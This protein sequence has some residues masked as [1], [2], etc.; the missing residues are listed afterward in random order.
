[1]EQ[2]EWHE[3]SLA[4]IETNQRTFRAVSAIVL[5]TPFTPIKNY[6]LDTSCLDPSVFLNWSENTHE[7]AHDKAVVFRSLVATVKSQPALDASLETKAVKFL[8]SVITHDRLSVDAFLG[9]FASFCDNS[10]TDFTQSVGVLISS[11]SQVITTATVKML[12]NLVVSCSTEV[13]LALVKADL[14]PRIINTLNPYSISFER[15]DIFHHHLMNII[16][17]SLWLASPVALTYLEIEDHDEQQAVHE[18]VLKQVLAPSEK[19]I[20]HLCENRYSIVDGRHTDFLGSG[21]TSFF[22]ETIEIISRPSPS[23]APHSPS[24]LSHCSQIE[25][26]HRRHSSLRRTQTPNLLSTVDDAILRDGNLETA[27]ILQ[28]G[29]SKEEIT[30]WDKTSSSIIILLH[31]TM[32]NLFS[33]VVLYL[34]PIFARPFVELSPE[35]HDLGV[36]LKTTNEKNLNAQKTAMETFVFP[37]GHFVGKNVNI[38]SASYSFVGTNSTMKLTRS[39]DSSKQ[40]KI[41]LNDTDSSEDGGFSWI[42][43]LVNSSLSLELWTLDSSE[44]WSSICSLSS[45]ELEISEST[46]I[47]NV[48]CSP[49]VVCGDEIGAGSLITLS[50]CSHFSSTSVLQPFV[51]LAMGSALCDYSALSVRGTSLLLRDRLLVLGTGPLFSFDISS[52]LDTR[53]A[54]PSFCSLDTQLIWSDLVNMSSPGHHLD[55][56]ASR[57]A[58]GQHVIG[59]SVS[60]CANHQQGTAM[61]DPT[62]GSD[63]H[64]INSSFTSCCYSPEINP[65]GDPTLVFPNSSSSRDNQSTSIILDISD[66][67]FSYSDQIFAEGDTTGHFLRCVF[68]NMRTS[69]SQQMGGAAILFSAVSSSLNITLCSFHNCTSTDRDS[70]GGAVTYYSVTPLSHSFT[71]LQS[72]FTHCACN[73]VTKGMG[74]GSVFVQTGTISQTTITGCAFENSYTSG[75]GGALSTGNVHLTITNTLFRKCS[76][77]F[78]GGALR[79]QNTSGVLVSHCAFR[80]CSG[81]S[82]YSGSKDVSYDSAI[83]GRI[84]P[85]S[86]PFSDSTSGGATVYCESLRNSSNW[87]AHV[88]RKT[89]IKR[90]DLSYTENSVKMTIIANDALLGSMTVLL[91]GANAPRLIQVPF[92]QDT[93][94]STTGE[95]EIT[96]GSSSFLPSDIAFRVRN[97]G[98]VGWDLHPIIFSVEAT[99][100]V[101][102]K[103]KIELNGINLPTI[104][105]LRIAIF[106]SSGG[107]VMTE[108]TESL[109]LILNISHS[110]DFKFGEKYTI[111]EIASNGLVLAVAHALSFTVPL[112]SAELTSISTTDKKNGTLH[113]Q[114]FGKH[115]YSPKYNVTFSTIDNPDQPH[116]RTLTFSSVSSTEL[117]TLEIPICDEGT[118][119]LVPDRVY[120]VTSAASLKHHQSFSIDFLHFRTP[121]APPH[122]SDPKGAMWAVLI[123]GIVMLSLGIAVLVVGLCC[124]CHLS[125]SRPEKS[126]I[127]CCAPNNVDC[128]P[129]CCHISIIFGSRGKPQED[130]PAI[131]V[132]YPK[133][134][135]KVTA[136]YVG[137]IQRPRNEPPRA[138]VQG[139]RRMQGRL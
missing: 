40:A 57:C 114:L 134:K 119:S 46:I 116:S 47:S 97:V 59:C 133:P 103:C 71:L 137:E 122:P 23:I 109:T 54:R 49:I 5:A 39:Q 26:V 120:K 130:G 118:Y 84:E 30:F 37:T 19:Y 67:S 87:I 79:M 43:D 77:G 131:E 35:L 96:T 78:F 90:V 106:N 44:L 127:V 104:T 129:Q 111:G 48:V 121:L 72:V 73:C 8:K 9:H 68:S 25:A 34:V 136:G 18:T 83:N 93:T 91:D 15:T 69:D 4:S 10:L 7:F 62:S 123:S 135:E 66:Q 58:K 99:L 89:R 14:I 29:T 80:E 128:C 6:S 36:F 132:K 38:T 98:L 31:H 86:F 70:S 101:D 24:P 60:Q 115:L 92:G 74:G 82:S 22:A 55:E 112:P 28:K 105:S 17:S 1:M 51:G 12:R 102:L 65:I 52:N 63:L 95:V 3:L 110:R 125:G 42:L 13:R 126:A 117:E 21:I 139:A 100:T 94:P 20:W 45:S 64:C 76:C 108:P 2:P 113:L 11:A 61:L 33:L 50:H 75:S 41:L 138:V 88:Q 85:S 27:T 56:M 107:Q 81:G 124:C 53:F 16:G 32:N